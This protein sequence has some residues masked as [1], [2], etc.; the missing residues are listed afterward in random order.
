MERE[1]SEEFWIFGL[2]ESV[3]HAKNVSGFYEKI[4]ISVLDTLILVCLSNI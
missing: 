4:K 2:D 1:K 3:G